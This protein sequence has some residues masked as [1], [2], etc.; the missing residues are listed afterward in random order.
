M[1]VNGIELDLWAVQP[2]TKDGKDFV[3]LRCENEGEGYEWEV[4]LT[5]SELHDIFEKCS[6]LKPLSCTR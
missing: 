6:K 1:K 3:R 2:R 4:E 5:Y